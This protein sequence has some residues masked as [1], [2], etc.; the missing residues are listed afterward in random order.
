MICVTFIEVESEDLDSGEHVAL[1]GLNGAGKT[2]L[3][4]LILGLYE[5]DKGQIRINGVDITKLSKKD[6]F[7]LFSVVFQEKMILPFMLDENIAL[8]RKENIDHDRVEAVLGLSGLSEDL[9]ER[10]ITQDTYMTKQLTQH[11]VF[12]S[13]GQEQKLH[14]A[15]ALYKEAP[16]LVLDEQQP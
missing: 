16:A 11:G 7:S 12:L 6:I 1:V 8:A 9:D 5:P 2:T 15:R 14:L 3:V 10:G 13:G 4:K